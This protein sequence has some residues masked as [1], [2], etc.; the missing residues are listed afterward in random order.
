MN[1]ALTF[2]FMLTIC[3]SAF[4]QRPINGKVTDN[5]GEGLIGASILVEGTSSGTATDLDGLFS[6]ELPE[7]SNVLV[8]S[9]T[10]FTTATYDV[11]GMDYVDIVLEQGEFLDEVIVVGYTT[12]TRIK[13]SVATSTVSSDK[14]EA[15]PNASIVQT[16]QGQVAG[17]NITTSSGQ[18]GGNSNIN[19]RGVTSINGNTEPLFIID[20]TPVDEDNFRSLNPNDIA[21][22]SVLKDAGAT[23]VYG[24]RGANGVI[25]IETKKGSYGSGVQ[26][27]YSGLYGV[28]SIQDN[29]YNLMNSQQQLELER[30]FGNGRGLELTDAEI[31]A[32]TTTDWSDVF[33]RNAFSQQHTLSIS[34]GT[35]NTNSFTSF[36]FTNQEGILESS[37]LKRYNVRN[38]LNARTL[39]EKLDISTNISLN[40]SRNDE[41]NQLGTGAINR[42]L[43][44]GGFQS[45]PYISP[46]DY[47]NG[48]ALL[49]PLTFANTPL[50]LYDRLQTYTRIEKE[51]KA[52]GSLSVAYKI[53]DNLQFTSTIGGDFTDQNLLRSEGPESFNSLLFAE[54]GNQTPGFQEQINTRVF[55][56]NFL[57][58]L[59]YNI[60]KGDHSVVAGIYS[61]YFRA[62][63]DLFGVFQLGLDP[64]TF[65]PGDGSG[66]VA[67]NAANDFFVDE[68]TA[69]KL[70]AGLFS[71]FGQVDYDY[72]GRYG[73]MATL[74]RDASYR[75]SASNR[76]GTFYSFAARWNIDQEPFMENSPFDLLKLRGS[77]GTTGN[78]RI[79]DAGGFLNYFGAPDLTEDFY[80]TGG[81]Y[82]GLNSIFLGQIGNTSL[83]WEKVT[84]M[85]IGI[86]FELLRNRLRGNLDF[87]LKETADLFQNRPISSIN[88]T[89][90]LL[91]NTG[92]LENRGIDLSLNYNILSSQTPDGLNL[93][94]TFIGNYN[95]Q[96]I[97]D[98][99]TPDGTIQAGNAIT[100]E[101]GILQEYYVYRYAGVN[102]ASGDLL[103]YDAEGGLT[104]NPSPD[105]DRIRTGK[106]V[107]PDFQGSFGFSLDYK[108]FFA[109]AQFNYTVGVYRF[110]FDLRGF[111][112][113]TTIGQYR[114]STDLL[115]AWTPD[116]R[117]TDIPAL[118]ASNLALDG[119]SDRHLK[120]SDYVRLRFVSVGYGFSEEF[121]KSIGLSK[122]KIFVNAE[123]MMT[124]TSWRGFDAESINSLANRYP[125]PATISAGI[126]VGF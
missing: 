106:N 66:F 39:D 76:W 43:V 24:N 29:D 126:E 62:N 60:T 18:P 121:A 17:L 125:T 37:G 111:Q 8:I 87:Y 90:A 64:R 27:S 78:Q 10:G 9:Y 110:D 15:R 109:S 40:Y 101:G 113:P 124:F 1:K 73:F 26:I 51:I 70:K 30:T 63:Y 105:R 95:K 68:G 58:S 16:L 54:V 34:N 36:G 85:N 102:P 103:F 100:A 47:V 82:A 38:N 6:L 67:D 81:G 115:R 94:L 120:N 69:Q 3:A 79:L 2:L 119:N 92:T 11:T 49:D 7:G 80:A 35:E 57:N 75:F 74:R 118:R 48:E 4:G 91:A 12:S 107:Y 50:F 93:V 46:N 104:E 45:V 31:A 5:Q 114:H 55:A 65:F 28:S 59:K 56:Y 96:E 122:L 112:D 21:S 72:K 53:L 20:G 117:V 98:L 88:A 99:P 32:A 25:I 89:S 116:N 108:R 33:F 22:V 42:N 71:Y 77:W 13:S 44:I 84:Q 83:R 123:N 14:I 23:A 52:V 97:I 41:P 86:D 19:L 61:E